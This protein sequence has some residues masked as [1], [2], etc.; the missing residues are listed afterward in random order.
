MAGSGINNENAEQLVKFTG[1]KEIHISSRSSYP[2]QMKYTRKTVSMGGLPQ[3]PE[4]EISQTDSLKIR[5]VV[6][7]VN[8]Y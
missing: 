3:I 6:Q 7:S 8:G 1:V 4:Y 2:S 5:S